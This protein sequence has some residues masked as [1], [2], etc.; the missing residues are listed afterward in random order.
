MIFALSIGS[1]ISSLLSWFADIFLTIWNA[2]VELFKWLC[3]KAYNVLLDLFEFMFKEF[4]DTFIYLLD[5][6][7]DVDLSCLDE[8]LSTLLKFWQG[9]DQIL[10]LSEVFSCVGFLFT[11][12]I[13]FTIVRIVVKL[14]PTIG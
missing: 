2:G 13:I 6:F 8:G 1:A 10:P 3:I 12:F 9:F 11:Y 7:P 4:V 5:Y 14:V